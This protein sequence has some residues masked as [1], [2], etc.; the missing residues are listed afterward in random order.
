MQ[1]QTTEKVKDKAPFL[2][3]I[4][5]TDKPLARLSE[6]RDSSK[7]THEKRN[8]RDVTETRWTRRDGKEQSH[9]DR[10]AGLEETGGSSRHTALQGRN[11]A[12]REICACPRQHSARWEPSPAPQKQRHRGTAGTA[13]VGTAGTGGRRGRQAGLGGP[14]LHFQRSAGGP[15]VAALAVGGELVRPRVG[16]GCAPTRE[17]QCVAGQNGRHALLK[18]GFHTK[19]KCAGTEGLALTA[20]SLGPGCP[21]RTRGPRT[22][23]SRPV[24]ASRGGR[25]VPPGVWMSGGGGRRPE[26]TLQWMTTTCWGSLSSQDSCALQM[27][28]TLSSGGACSSGQPT[29]RICNERVRCPTPVQVRALGGPGQMQ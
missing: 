17:N 15:S 20:P 6:K 24:R 5:T 19:A 29:S 3:N 8:T 9:A 23:A 13:G 1:P 10:L 27:A 2:E 4:H 21:L 28:H 7:T 16:P 12:K 26:L 14:N 18:R 22:G 11:R 25:A